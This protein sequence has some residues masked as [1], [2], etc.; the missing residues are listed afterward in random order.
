[1]QKTLTIASAVLISIFC[2]AIYAQ[3]F[4]GA[5]PTSTT[6]S[7][8]GGR[9]TI[10]SSN[11]FKNR[12]KQRGQAVDKNLTEQIKAELPPP[13]PPPNPATEEQASKQATSQPR[14]PAQQAGTQRPQATT[15]QRPAQA[16]PQQQ[17]TPNQPYTGFGT[18]ATPSTGGSSGSGNTGSGSS[19]SG[20]WNVNY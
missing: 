19:G 6:G 10:L 4:F 1:M 7:T 9:S 15:P 2:S 16:R 13:P 18:G 11:D 20:G 12:V 14:Q 17:S 5:P 3:S 8:S